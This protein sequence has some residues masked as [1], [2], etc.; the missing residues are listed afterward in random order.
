[1]NVEDEMFIPDGLCS[2]V[3]L[4]ITLHG[5]GNNS[6]SQTG[7]WRPVA[8]REKIIVLA[9]NSI[10][11]CD[12]YTTWFQAGDEQL[13]AAKVHEVLHRFPVDQARIYCFGHSIGAT[14]A[15][16]YGFANRDCVAA[17]ALNEP[18]ERVEIYNLKGEPR[19]RR[20]PLGIWVGEK[21]DGYVN[22]FDVGSKLQSLYRDD[23]NFLV[24]LNVISNY[25]HKDI[26]ERPD[27]IAD[28]WSFLRSHRL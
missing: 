25:R 6:D 16:L 13:L 20:L 15:L 28:I 10:S 17:V 18:Y 19:P 3:P 9:P 21:Q 12:S 11:T 26:Y 23:Q 14:R 22:N 8:A 1:M 27:V 2:S 24:S 5:G 7:L 4:L